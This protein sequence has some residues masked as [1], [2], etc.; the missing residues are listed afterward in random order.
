MQ[1]LQSCQVQCSLLLKPEAMT[2]WLIK[3]ALTDQSS[4]RPHTRERKHF[5]R[6]QGAFDFA[7]GR[8]FGVLIFFFVGLGKATCR[9]P[10]NSAGW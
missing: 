9:P 5:V 8:C 7:L 10:L 6:H 3:N 1:L 4:A 2:L